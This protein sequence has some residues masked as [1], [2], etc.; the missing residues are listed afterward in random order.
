MQTA[1]SHKW[2]AIRRDLIQDNDLYE[3]VVRFKDNDT[4]HPPDGLLIFEAV[5]MLV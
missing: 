4:P 2:E 5:R 3:T 1:P